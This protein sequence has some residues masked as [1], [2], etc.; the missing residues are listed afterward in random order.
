M[1]IFKTKTGNTS[2]NLTITLKRD[3]T[4]VDL[5]GAAVTIKI[6]NDRSGTITLT[7]GSCT[8]SSP[9]TSGIITYTPTA[10]DFPAAGRY[11]GVITV[12]FSGTPLERL[13]EDIL[14]IARD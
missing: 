12:D 6:V 2:P 3:G 13:F 11:V 4:V 8:V 9:T 1:V 5:T 7:A 14:V 10:T